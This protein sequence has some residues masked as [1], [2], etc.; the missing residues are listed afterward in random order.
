MLSASAKG[1]CQGGWKRIN[2]KV[3]RRGTEKNR[4]NKMESEKEKRIQQG[5]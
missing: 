5:I 2:L 1:R 3:Q 4:N